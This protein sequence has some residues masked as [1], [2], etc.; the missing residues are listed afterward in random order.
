MYI[1]EFESK[2]RSCEEW[3]E[4]K[5]LVYKILLDGPFQY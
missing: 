2:S 1:R 5:T 3:F 4:K